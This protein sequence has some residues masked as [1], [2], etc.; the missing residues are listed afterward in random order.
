[1]ITYLEFISSVYNYYD[2]HRYAK[3]I[4]KIFHTYI[5]YLLLSRFL[6]I[7]I[8]FLYTLSSILEM[9]LPKKAKKQT[10]TFKIF[11][12]YGQSHQFMTVSIQKVIFLWPFKLFAKTSY[13]FVDETVL[14][15]DSSNYDR[16]ICRLIWFVCLKMLWGSVGGLWLRGSVGG[17]WLGGSAV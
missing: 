13:P 15:Y 6:K 16:N 9:L 12:F 14:S 2:I 5:T 17:L 8:R 3:I 4:K 1:M 10:E 7:A 11:S